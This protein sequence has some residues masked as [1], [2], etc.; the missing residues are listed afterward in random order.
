MSSRR[1]RDASMTSACDGPP[2]PSHMAYFPA[3][4][5]N[6]T[7]VKI[8]SVELT[9]TFV[10]TIIIGTIAPAY[11][12]EMY[13]T[14]ARKV[15][16][17]FDLDICDSCKVF[18]IRMQPEHGAPR[19]LDTH[20]AIQQIKAAIKKINELP[21]DWIRI[22]R[23][24]ARG[25]EFFFDAV[26]YLI[27]EWNFPG[28]KQVQFVTAGDTGDQEMFRFCKSLCLS[29]TCKEVEFYNTQDYDPFG[30]YRRHS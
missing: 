16:V 13:E 10:P 25:T 18:P 26:R 6:L 17:H 2:S 15:G 27:K 29:K 19:A 9:K 14:D 1:L 5:H 22:V 21:V 4:S 7:V 12:A 24:G 30:A 11:T 28:D 20:D 23:I 8:R 3:N